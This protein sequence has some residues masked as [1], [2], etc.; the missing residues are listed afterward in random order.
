MQ[1]KAAINRSPFDARNVAIL[2]G[3]I[4]GAA[5]FPILLGGQTLCYRDFG[6]MG[7]P[8]AAYHR[9]A[10][11][12]G[13]FPLWNPYSNCGVP[14]F[15][16]WGTMVL[17]PLSLLYVLLPMPWSLNFFCV[18]H[19]WVGGIGMYFLARRWV[20]KEWPSA[21][22]GVAFLSNGITQAALSWPNYTAALALIPWVVLTVEKAWSERSHV[23]RHV[24]LAIGLTAFQLLTG[25]P[26][27]AVLT[28]IVLGVFWLQRFIGSP[29]ERN[30]LIFRQLT[31]SGGAAGLCAAQ[32]LPFFQLLEH[33][34]RTPGFAAEKW[35]L[36]IWGWANFLLPR[37]IPSPRRK[38]LIS[39]TVRNFSLPPISGA[40]C[41]FSPRS[42]SSSASG[43]S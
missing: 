1:T 17:Y 8:T 35:A 36:P 7:I 2:L 25:V 33:S 30:G 19:L 21:L 14:F 23:A 20:G 42:R 27:L 34:Q 10:I 5:F 6:V 28:W 24:V 3:L 40:D 37:F 29:H 12:N 18:L 13:E 41:F 32:L 9:A 43:K 16:Q 26:E 15:A 39:N 38:G 31:I 4:L 11:L 22:A